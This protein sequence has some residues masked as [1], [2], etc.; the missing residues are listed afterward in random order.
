MSDIRWNL[1]RNCKIIRIRL[2]TTAN[3]TIYF[4]IYK[5]YS[6]NITV[7][8]RL[9]NLIITKIH[10]FATNGNWWICIIEGNIKLAS[11]PAY[12]IQLLRLCI[13]RYT[14]TVCAQIENSEIGKESTEHDVFFHFCLSQFFLNYATAVETIKRCIAS[15]RRFVFKENKR[16]KKKYAVSYKVKTFLYTKIRVYCTR[17]NCNLF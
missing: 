11:K 3:S 15:D 8:N 17:D 12:F 4:L 10:L 16:A 14:A 2:T 1:M 5:N 13:S 9:Y 6:M 7:R